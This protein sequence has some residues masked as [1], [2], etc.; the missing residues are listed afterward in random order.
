MVREIVKRLLIS[1]ARGFAVDTAVAQALI[2]ESVKRWRRQLETLGVRVVTL[3][4]NHRP[5][6]VGISSRGK[7]TSRSCLFWWQVLRGRVCCCRTG[8]RTVVAHW[9]SL[10][11]RSFH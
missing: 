9:S 3:D 11:T 10:K 6:S 4:V 2:V 5:K 8:H 1:P 7:V